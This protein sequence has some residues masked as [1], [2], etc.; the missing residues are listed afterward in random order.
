MAHVQ[1]GVLWYLLRSVGVNYFWIHKLRAGPGFPAFT[2]KTIAK[3]I[4]GFRPKLGSV[5]S[6]Q[7]R[8]VGPETPNSVWGSGQLP[9]VMHPHASGDGV[10]CVQDRWRRLSD[11]T[12][13][14]REKGLYDYILIWPRVL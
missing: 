10:P 13:E 14:G 8:Q 11:M 5:D 4:R 1:G 9:V 7:L 3:S 6:V 2:W 12:S